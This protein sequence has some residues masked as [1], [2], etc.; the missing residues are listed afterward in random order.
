MLW[1]MLG[2]TGATA[3]AA[4]AQPA[5]PDRIIVTARHSRDSA[6]EVRIH[7]GLCD[8]LVARVTMRVFHEPRTIEV[9]WG[10]QSSTY[11]EASAFAADLLAHPIALHHVM[12]RPGGGL[13]LVS[14]MADPS[15][16]DGY[17]YSVAGFDTQ[18]RLVHYTGKLDQPRER[19]QR[20]VR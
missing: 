15:R 5:P 3:P 4:A 9:Q 18:G 16:P 7:E 19:V 20:Y 6:D 14:T 13:D 1:L 11:D 10:A 12:C 17:F 2:L 8:G